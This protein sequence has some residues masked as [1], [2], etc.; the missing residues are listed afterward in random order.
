MYTF[1][2]RQSQLEGV[3]NKVMAKPAW[4]W[5]TE[6]TGKDSRVDKV[7]MVQI[8]RPE[9]Q[10]VIDTRQVNIQELTPFFESEEHKKIAHYGIFDY[11]LTKGTFGIE[12]EGIRCT[13]TADVLLTKGIKYRGFGL[14]AVMK[15]WLNIDISKDQQKS[16]I[17][18]G[19]EPFTRDQIEYGARDTAYLLPLLQKQLVKIKEDQM[20]SIYKLECDFIPCLGD[21]QHNGIMLDVEK[22]QATI[23][24]NLDS[25]AEVE[26]KLDEYAAQY[27]G[28]D[29]WGKPSIN[30]GSP[31]Q[32]LT[33]LKRMNVRYYFWNKDTRKEEE[34]LIDKTD[35]ATFKKIIGKLKIIELLQDWRSYSV[36]VNTF[37][38][39]Y[40][41]AIHPATG[42]IQTSYDQLGA[43]SGRLTK[44]R[45]CAVN[46]LN[47]PR[48]IRFRHGFRAKDDYLIETDDYSGC[49]LRIL[50]EYSKDPLFV[51]AFKEKIDLHC[52]VATELYGVHVTKNNEN[53]KLRQPAKN[54]NFGIAYG[55]G[56]NKLYD[57]LCAA[58]FPVTRDQARE[59]YNNY[60][61]KFKVAVNFLREAGRTAVRQG[62]LIN[63]NGRRRYWNVPD[64]E[65]SEKYPLGCRDPKY[66]G[67]IAAIEREGGN[68]MIQSVNADMTKLGMINIRKYRKIN[69]IR[70]DFVNQV[71][72]EIVTETHKD[73]SLMFHPRKQAIMIEASNVYL[74][75]IPME[76]EGHVG[77]TWTK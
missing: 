7:I 10:F 50:A 28:L 14:A 44:G 33:L 47:L 58:G 3:L 35:D 63:L 66:K 41:R 4:G 64:P 71:Y 56:P 1:I 39:P 37:G 60:C 75:T 24:E 43:D 32:V 23:K 16:F 76:V 25:K 52:M 17:G 46:L 45:D 65:N 55:M 34:R 26:A 69:K 48:D 8:G 36:L 42:R 18:M 67:V 77:L 74:K 72:D 5:D 21:M 12:V 49:E 11:M 53:S 54:L 30:Y 62:Y 61:D 59:L 51:K 68:Q 73:D 27:Y 70:S 13:L 57:D 38:E 29:L 20:G 22:W 40:I 31:D 9:E 2:D 15:E 19:S 6:T